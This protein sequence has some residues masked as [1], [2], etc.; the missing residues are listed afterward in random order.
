MGF[1]LRRPR[2]RRRFRTEQYIV[3]AFLTVILAGALLLMLP[4]ASRSGE[5]CGFLTAMFTATSATCVTGLVL[6]DTYVQWSGF[7]QVVI[8]TLIQIGGLGFMSII[9]V[10]F[11]LLHRKIGLQHRLV[12][13][14]GF[15]LNEMEGVVHLVRTV[16]LWTAIFEGTAAAILTVRFWG[17]YGL[18]QALRWGIFHAVSAFCNAGFDLFGK[19]E[20]GSSLG[21]FVSDPV[22]NWVIIALII[23]G[24]LGFYVWVDLARHR[25][26]SRL[27]V[28]TK[29]VLTIT[30]FLVLGGAAL[31]AVLEWD[32]PRT[33]GSLD[34]GEKLL[35]SIFQSV[36][37]RT[38]GFAALP[39]GEL[40]EASKACSS[41]LML[42]G[43]S[44]GSTAGGIKT[45]TIGI[46]FLSA[47]SA[48]R[49]Q[50]RLSV[51][52]RTIGADQ[53][54]QAMTIMF[55]MVT[56]AFSGAVIL[57]AGGGFSFVDS[58]YETAS[59]LGT[60][61]LTTGITPLVST[62]AK[63]MLILFMFFGR[64]G[65]MTISFGFLLGNRAKE[66]YRYA[67]AK[68]LIG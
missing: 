49:G 11:F 32:N 21:L 58:L 2:Y 19:L 68:V 29:L 13:A 55:L 7:G 37:C 18:G 22:V 43:G 53:V 38:A 41:V 30:A 4:V 25:R 59:A 60:A 66:R 34:T 28:H 56:L 62:G 39:Q 3:L 9:S 47:V 61:G 44:A 51:F 8:L 10:F 40:T 5:S 36:T 52:G 46:L 14:Q 16:L 1:W 33:L 24:G 17:E 6:A 45:V 50:S 65:I 35:A 26:F 12:M 31:F 42:I 27:S 23:L 64:V 67:E 48:A 63:W 57:S 54:R 20:P 15:S